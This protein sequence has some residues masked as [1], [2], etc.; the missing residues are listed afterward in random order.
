VKRLFFKLFVAFT[1]IT[2]FWACKEGAPYRADL[3]ARQIPIDSTIRQD[4]SVDAYIAPFRKRLNEVLDAP[5]AYAPRDLTKT[6]GRWNTPLGNLMADILLERANAVFQLR[7]NKTVDLSVLNHGGMRSDIARGPVT[8]RTAYQVMPFEN[9]L[10]VIGVKGST[11]E[12]M[13]D[14]LARE[15]RP[16][17]IAGMEI[18]LLP[19]GTVKSARVGGDPIDT[20]RTYYLATSDYLIGG[21]DGMDFFTDRVSLFSTD[22]TI[23]NA[24]VDYLKEKD[25]L[26]AQIDNR[27]IQLTEE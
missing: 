27:F 12:R 3:Q 18:V 20:A 11:L 6:E 13:V 5:L 24:M 9:G 7:E 26:M 4:D 15:T 10:V 8:E 19:D 21:G 17:A 14:F 23:R 16:H 2:G 25:T 1:T 22:Y